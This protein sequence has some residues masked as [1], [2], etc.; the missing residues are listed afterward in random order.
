V[1]SFIEDPSLSI[2]VKDEGCGMS[3]RDLNRIFEPFFTT[4]ESGTGLGL[5][6]AANIVEQHGGSLH[7]TNNQGRGMTFRLDLPLDRTQKAVSTR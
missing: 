4:K 2:E 7:G 5:A 1:R 3:E 6:V